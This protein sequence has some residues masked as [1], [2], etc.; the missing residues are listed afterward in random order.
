MP[1][2]DCNVQTCRFNNDYG[3]VRENITVGGPRAKDAGETCCDSFEELRSESF[4]NSVGE[5]SA[6]VEIQCAA[7]NC[8]HNQDCTCFAD[9]VDVGGSNAT[10]CA[11][12]LCGTFFQR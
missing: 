2:L 1:R 3:C 8:V 7:G 4:R 12:T 9:R 10:A 6:Q 5:P 11:D